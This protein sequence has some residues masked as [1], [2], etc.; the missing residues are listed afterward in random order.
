MTGK[1]GLTDQAARLMMS[2][3]VLIN[4][5][6]RLYRPAITDRGHLDLKPTGLLATN[7]SDRAK[8]AVIDFLQRHQNEPLTIREIAAA[9]FYS[10][11]HTW[12]ILAALLAEGVIDRKEARSTAGHIYTIREDQP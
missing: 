12:S 6:G 2:D 1:Q 8:V 10:W 9:V 4:V 5:D 3:S 7:V 11:R